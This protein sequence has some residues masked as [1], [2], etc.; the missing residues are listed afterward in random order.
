MSVVS[1]W[2]PTP[3]AD[4]ADL[5]LRGLAAME[6]ARPATTDLCLELGLSVWI[7]QSGASLVEARP[8][9]L[10]MR[11]ALVQASGLT[12]ATEPFPLGNVDLRVDVVNLARYL[13]TLIG[14]AAAHAGCRP[15][16]MAER[17]LREMG[18]RFRSVPQVRAIG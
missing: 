17:A 7:Q 10:A 3:R 18:D 12:L 13:R 5:V 15:S 6:S 16:V 9:M 2:A 4:F 1:I 8:A 14:R 11:T